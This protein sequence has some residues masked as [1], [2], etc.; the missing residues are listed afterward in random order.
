M[1]VYFHVV[2]PDGV[3]ANVTQTQIDDQ[4]RVMNLA[5]TGAYGGVKTGFTFQLAGVT[6]TTNADWFNAKPGSPAER[7][8]KKALDRRTPR[9]AELLLD[10]A[11]GV[12]LGWAY[13]PVLHAVAHVPRRHRRRTG[14]FRCTS[15]SRRATRTR[16]TCAAHRRPREPATGSER[17]STPF[18]GGP[19]SRRATTSTTQP[20]MRVPTNGCPLGKDTC[21]AKPGLDPIHNYMD[22]SY[23]SCYFEF[24]AG[25]AQ[26]MQRPLALLPTRAISE[27][28]VRRAA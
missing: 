11:R 10:H 23:D 4:I 26:R 18:Y 9:G 17:S 3:I 2:S 22:Y 28:D 20:P 13:L 25:P 21:A 1:P 19:Q 7:A 5:F 24:T 6:R 16:T 15:D 27:R 14:S 8:M 12:Y